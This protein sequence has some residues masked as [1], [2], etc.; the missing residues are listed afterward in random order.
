MKKWSPPEDWQKITT[1]DLHTQG[2]PFRVIVDGFPDPS[3][4]TILAKRRYVRENL[5][6]MRRAIM[7]EPRGHSDMYG[8]IVTPPVS[9][10]ADFGVIFMH[11]EGYSSMCGHGIIG[12]STLVLETGMMPVREPETK[13]KIDTPAGVVTAHAMVSNGRVKKVYFKNVPSF[14]LALDEVVEVKGLGEVEYDLAFGGAFYAYVQVKDVGLSCTRKDFQALMEKGMMIKRAIKS[15]RDIIHPFEEDLSFL[16]GIIFIDSPKSKGSHSR[17]VC[18]FADGQVDR[19]PTGTGVSGR[20][21][22][23][24][25]RGEISINQ[26]IVIESII[27]SRFTGRIL[28][29]TT[30]G[31]YPAIIPI[32]EGAAHITGRHEFLLDPADP[33]K[34]GFILR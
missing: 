16:Y 4:E 29:A 8:C 27:N 20:L 10:D 11:N 17:N 18:I 26:P 22:I 13:I 3:G 28:E 33:L 12:I 30:Y 9:S 1:I 15:T 34:G 25:S 23:H 5:D 14:V 6:H 32:V 31:P 21:A 7:W 2:E 24:F 19:C